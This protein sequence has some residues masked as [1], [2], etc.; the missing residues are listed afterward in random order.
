MCPFMRLCE[1]LL[2]NEQQNFIMT[3]PMISCI[4]LSAG[5]SRRFG[6]PKALANL[7]GISVLERL[8]KELV[9]SQ[10]GEIIVVLGDR[11]HEIKPHLLDHK[12]VKFVYNKEFE[13]GQTSSFKAGLRVVIGET[14]GILLLPVDVPLIKSATIDFLIDTFKK[15]TPLILIPTFNGR[16]GHPPIFSNQLKAELLE[17]KDSQGLNAF[18]HRFEDRILLVPT[19]DPAIVHSFNTVEEFN[20]IKS[21]ISK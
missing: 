10:V 6:S 9:Q 12:K 20:A 17:L 4:L 7:G 18:E 2:T 16:K 15:S 5:L 11:A 8:Q 21:M 14:K 3:L 13:W 1:G 19:Q